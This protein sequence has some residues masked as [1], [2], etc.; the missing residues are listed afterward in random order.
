VTNS[1]WSSTG[2]L[3][4]APLIAVLVPCY[5]EERTIGKVVRDFGA[6]LPTAAIYVYDNNSTD[7]TSQRAREAGAIVRREPR[8]G[9]GFVVARMFDE[10]EADAYVLVDGDDTY[11]AAAVNALLRPVLDGSADMTVGSRIDPRDTTA[12]RRFHVFGNR[13]VCEVINRIFRCDIHDIFSG[14]RVMSRSVVK[15]VPVLARGFD[16]ETELTLQTLYRR[17]LIREIATPYR[18]RPSGSESKLRTLPDGAKVLLRLFLL[19]QSYKPLT[20]FGLVGLAGLACSIAAG[21]RPVTEYLQ[22]QY[23][24]SVPRAILAAALAV[25]ALLNAA[26][27]VILHNT[28]FRLQE[29]ERVF[30]KRTPLRP[31]ARQPPQAR[32]GS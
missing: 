12:F 10:I 32:A 15:S 29:L 16:V 25:I 3:A 6:A 31:A 21:F 18:S 20:F 5:Q 7:A 22:D 23:V 28:N 4:S 30:V 27:G 2:D 14:Y 17:F 8:Q 13:L 1:D 11:D 26:I 9:K 24:Y 19:L